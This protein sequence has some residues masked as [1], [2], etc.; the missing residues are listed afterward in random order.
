MK[1]TLT[2]GRLHDGQA[3]SIRYMT[4]TDLPKLL[5]LQEKVNDSMTVAAHLQPLTEEEFTFILSDHGMIAGV[6]IGEKLIGF[7]AMLAPGND[8]EHLGLD[9]GIPEKELQHVLYSEISCIDPAYRGNHLQTIL[10]ELLFNLVDPEQFHYICT[11]VAPFNIPSIK[12]KLRLDMKIVA[13][14]E[15]YGSKLRYILL[16][17]LKGNKHTATASADEVLMEMGDIV[18]QQELLQNGYIG[19][20]ITQKDDVWFVTYRKW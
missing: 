10:G 12:D 9:C 6:F 14:K 18:R 17:E 13:L 3:Y 4:E 15:K 5:E 16:R 2:H 20:S 11:T 7:R 19:E 1:Q 8:E